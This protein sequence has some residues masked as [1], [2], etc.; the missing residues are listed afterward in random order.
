MGN[1]DIIDLDVGF[2]LIVFFLLF[3]FFLA[4]FSLAWVSKLGIKAGRR[5]EGSRKSRDLYGWLWS[6]GL[7]PSLGHLP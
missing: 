2:F 6:G 7:V 3:L 4:R 5:K 1:N